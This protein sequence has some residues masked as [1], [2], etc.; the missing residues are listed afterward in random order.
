MTPTN[1]LALHNAVLMLKDGFE[2]FQIVKYLWDS[3]HIGEK[4][5]IEL[6]SKAETE[7]KTKT[8]R[9]D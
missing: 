6:I 5:A 8:P 4:D 9:K 2:R 1:A 3:Y 7:L